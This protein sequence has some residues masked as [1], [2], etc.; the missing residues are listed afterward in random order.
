MSQLL[1]KASW[2]GAFI[3]PGSQVVSFVCTL[4]TRLSHLTRLPREVVSVL[5]PTG[6]FFILPAAVYL[7]RRRALERSLEPTTP[8][9]AHN[10]KRGFTAPKSESYDPDVTDPPLLHKHSEIKSYTTSRYTYPGIR[11]FFRPHPKADQLPVSPAP[12]PLLVF[13]HGLGGSAAQFQPLL[14][15]LTNIAPCLAIDLPGCGRSTFAPSAWAAYTTDSL[16]ELLETVI[17]DYRDRDAE[18]SIIL[19]GHSMGASL[20]ACLASR[21]IPHRTNLAEYVSGLVAICPVAHPPAQERAKYFRMLLRLPDF[22]LDV[23]RLWDR[24][25]GINSPSVLRFVGPDADTE[26]KRLQYLYNRQSRTPVWR[27]MAMGSMPSFERGMA[28]GG[29]PGTDVWM[30]IN[31]PVFLI[32]GAADAVTGP[33]ELDLILASLNREETCEGSAPDHQAIVDSAAPI[34]SDP[35][36]REHRAQSIRDIREEDFSRDGRLANP[37]D[38][39]EDP[40]TPGESPASI[41]PLPRHPKKVVKSII[42]PAPA[43]H[44]LLYSPSTVRVLAALISDFLATHIS[45]RLSLAWQLRYFS[46]EGK[47]DVKNLAKWKQVVPV[48]DPIAG[49]FRAMKTLREVDETH[50]P[51]VFARNWGNT[52]KDIIDISHDSPVYDPRGL[53]KAGVRYHKLPTVS[54]VPPTDAEVD[55]FIAL[56]DRIREEQKKRAHEEG[57]GENYVVGVHCH[58]GFNRTGYFI[59]CYLVERCGYGVKEAIETFAK[60]RPNGIR[61]SHFLDHLFVRYSGLHVHQSCQ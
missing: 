16:V 59:V 14:T 2:S 32:A 43:G 22:V 6:A 24:R 58:Y 53:E 37:D 56:V 27:R 40:V 42:L 8:R 10:G 51:A 9:A 1:D 61:H 60:A 36:P 20:A 48:S 25:G 12:V 4:T 13:I 49:V 30:S 29:L 17:E 7:V 21:A 34:Q 26:A 54:K 18:Q 52:V 23:L 28:K 11:V 39:Q 38:S 33:K 57:W 35:H 41:P 50:C 5:L 47:W 19:I 46:R 44:G 55:A 31:V 45:G 15:S 3:A